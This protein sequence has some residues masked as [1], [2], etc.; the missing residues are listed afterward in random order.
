ERFARFEKKSALV[1]AEKERLFSKTVAPSEALD[2]LT[3]SIG[4][5]RVTTGI[6]LAEL[7]RRP[8]VT[9]EMLAGVDTERPELPQDVIFTVQ[10]DIKY[11]GYIKKQ[12]ADA[13]RFEKLESKRLDE[14]LD[15]MNIRG[16]STEAAQK[17][18]KFRPQSIGAA[19]RISGVSPADIAV[20][21]IFLDAH[22][23]KKGEN[24]GQS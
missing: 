12:L 11:E 2:A 9:Y 20:L 14:N 5:P 23:P 16:L 3:D 13:E 21:L 18:T 1:A 8:A 24:D 4:E 10:T 6:K 19:S 7:L 15:Y 22:K 17:L